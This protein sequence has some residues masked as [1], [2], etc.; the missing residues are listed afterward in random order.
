MSR[1]LKFL[2]AIVIG[3]AAGLVYGWAISPVQY[4]NTS[5]DSLRTD[6]RTDYILMT[7]EVFSADHDADA[8]ARRLAMLGSAPPVQIATQG[9]QY[10]LQSG[11]APT[12]LSALRD[13][14]DALQTW[15][16]AG[17]NAP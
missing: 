13:L 6:Y 14:V 8:A 16:P 1:G 2:I 12:D 17:G 5:P 10:A 9:L 11:F 15:Q 3:L 4:T 7:A